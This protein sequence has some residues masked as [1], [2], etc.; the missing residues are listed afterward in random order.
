LI[1]YAK[2]NPGKV[3]YAVHSGQVELDEGYLAKMAGVDMVPIPYKGGQQ[4]AIAVITNESQ[5][6][7]V[8]LAAAVY[9]FR[10]I[11][12]DRNFFRA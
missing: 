8:G 12:S 11:E 4:A 9:G 3:N 7:M 5:L 1:A 2:A 6:M 10:P